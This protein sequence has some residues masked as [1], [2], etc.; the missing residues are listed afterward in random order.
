MNDRAVRKYLARWAEPEA[1]LAERIDGVYGEI[2]VVPAR[3]ERATLADELLAWEPPAGRTLVILVENESEP[4]AAAGRIGEAKPATRSQP[5][6]AAELLRGARID[7]LR[8]DRASPGRRLAAKEGVG[9]ARK[10]GGDIALAIAARGGLASPWIHMTD[11]DARMSAARFSIARTIDA[12]I[13]H[14]SAIVLPF[15]HIVA[16]A[17]LH[18]PMRRHEIWLRVHVLGLQAAGSPYAFPAIGSVIAVRPESYARVRG[19]PNRE[20]GEDFH[21]LD[22][23]AKIGAV[24]V[25]DGEPVEI[26]ARR[27]DRVP[28]GTG[29]ALARIAAELERGED[30]RLLDP[31]CFE[32][33]GLW[34]AALNRLAEHADRARFARETEE[35]GLAAAGETLGARDA[36]ARLVAGYERGANL[37]RHLHTWFDGLLTVRFLNALRD[38]GIPPLVW[39]DALRRAPFLDGFEGDFDAEI[40]LERLRRRGLERSVLGLGVSAE[41]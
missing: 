28:F 33:L 7:L 27:S 12:E 16:E 2:V 37:R 13:A 22:K 6:P 29:P 20:A 25:A 40:A 35:G 5:P 9:R 38:G 15:R 3:R 10:I 19:V 32:K 21:F 36:I 11:A 24:V 30:M 18:E 14:A 8:V 31:V 1:S 23:V 17:A 4:R 41:S 34:I 26:E 39:R